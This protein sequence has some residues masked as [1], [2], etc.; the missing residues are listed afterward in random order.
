LQQRAFGVHAPVVQDVAQYVDLGWWERVCKEIAAGKGHLG[1]EQVVSDELFEDRTYL[2]QIETHP[3]Q[4]RMPLGHFTG[5]MPC[6]VPRS[7]NV[8]R[9]PHGKVLA[10]AIAGAALS[11]LMADEWVFRTSGSAYVAA[12]RSSSCLTVL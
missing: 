10:S 1:A 2:W 12:K 5:I 6:A 11:T 3:T 4:V 8:R 7:Q 9:R